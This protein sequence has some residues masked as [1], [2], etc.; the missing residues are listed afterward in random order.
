MAKKNRIQAHLIDVLMRVAMLLGE[1]QLHGH[2]LSLLN[3]QNNYP[4]KRFVIVN[5]KK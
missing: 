1:G 5:F 4:A 3:I 2:V